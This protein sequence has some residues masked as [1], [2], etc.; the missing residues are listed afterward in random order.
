MQRRGGDDEEDIELGELENAAFLPRGTAEVERQAA[1]GGILKWVRGFVAG[2]SRIRVSHHHPP[3]SLSL[4]LSISL[5]ISGIIPR[6]GRWSCG[7]TCISRDPAD[8][9]GAQHLHHDPGLAWFSERGLCPCG[10]ASGISSV[11]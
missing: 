9:P 6:D 8:A 1:G 11:G 2:L 5:E 3:F 10:G 4:S 7:L